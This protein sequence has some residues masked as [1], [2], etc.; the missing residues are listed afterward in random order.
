MRQFIQSST[1]PVW[2]LNILLCITW[3]FGVTEWT[4][5]SRWEEMGWCLCSSSRGMRKKAVVEIFLQFASLSLWVDGKELCTLPCTIPP[6]WPQKK[7]KKEKKRE[8]AKPRQSLQSSTERVGSF[9][10]TSWPTR[11]FKSQRASERAPKPATQ[12][13]GSRSAIH[14]RRLTTPDWAMEFTG[15]QD[16]LAH[17]SFLL[18]NWDETRMAAVHAKSSF[19][20]PACAQPLSVVHR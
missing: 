19:W 15:G 13:Y 14:F 6:C 11:P 8:Q 1:V 12:R 9:P 17:D 20:P 7:R 5:A 4:F 10:G 3:K 16:I 18:A 2:H